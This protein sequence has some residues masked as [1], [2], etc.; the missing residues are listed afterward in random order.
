MHRPHALDQDLGP[1]DHERMLNFLRTYGDLDRGFHY[2]GSEG[3]GSDRYYGA[4]DTTLEPRDPLDMRALLDAN[5]WHG[6]L[7]E[8]ELDYQA[9]MFQPVGGMDRIAFAFAKR[10]GN[11]VQYRAAVTGVRK[12]S[13]GVRVEYQHEG[14]KKALDADYCICTVPPTVLAKIP[15]D[16]SPAVQAAIASCAYSDAY[17]IAWETPRFWER[18]YNIYGGISW[19]SGHPIT[20]VW[21]PSGSLFAET[22]VVVSGY[23]TERGSAF[24][25]L[26]D[27]DAKLAA[28]RDAMDCFTP[29]T[30]NN[31]RI[32]S[33]ST[34]PKFPG[35]KA[36]GSQ[37]AAPPADPDFTRAPTKIFFNP[38]AAS[39]LRAIT[40]ATSAHGR[41]ARWFRRTAWL[42]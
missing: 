35:T 10:L 21:Y 32:P 18:D 20:L 28:S 19:L 1:A 16:F 17:K 6:M 2:A 24:G 40:S 39:I 3:A 29:A 15:N 9:T 33:T 41:K 12:T 23:A 11:A 4:G 22:G 30:A 25:A 14:A 27:R 26:P 31:W 8:D 34:G 5:F 7:F 13:N 42:A 37:D 38:T 36:D